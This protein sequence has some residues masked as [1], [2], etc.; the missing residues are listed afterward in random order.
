M[1][2]TSLEIKE[3]QF[4][5][6]GTPTYAGITW[7]GH[8]LEGLLFNSRM[9]QAIFDDENPGTRALW[10]YPDT[11]KWD[12][13][14][15]TREFCASLPE[16]RR[17]GLLAVTVGLQGGGPVFTKAIYDTYMNSAFTPDGSFKPA[18]FDRLLQVLDASDHAGMIVIV[19][20][21]YHQQARF[22]NDASV[23]PRV[24]G[25]V[26]DWLLQTGYTN[27]IVD[28]ANETRVSWG[29]PLVDPSRVH[30][31]LGIVKGKALHGRR[32]RAS[33]SSSGGWEIP[34]GKWLDAED[35]SMPHGNGC[36][37]GTLRM[38][39]EAIRE[40]EEY[41]KRPRPIIV[42][43]DSTFVENLEAA[44]EAGASWGFYCQGFGSEY[45]DLQDWTLHGR[46]KTYEALSGFQT[47]PVNWSIN[48]LDK[49]R[50]FDRLKVITSGK[51]P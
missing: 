27:I 16:Y 29:H 39:I 35:V 2:N 24:T 17:H 13:Q 44:I 50:F 32:L 19:N 21:F 28:I 22:F 42:N 47:V 36:S 15:N 5:I 9:I 40:E 30:E 18:Y 26:T 11:G 34:Y 49:K 41:I 45:K 14:R 37:P 25:T 6:N 12:A 46:E 10:K 1:S 38:K 7:H 48:T 20:Y 51:E 43:E 33:T 23:L 31:L 4:A 8:S 3:T